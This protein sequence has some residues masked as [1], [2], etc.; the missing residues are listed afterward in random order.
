MNKKLAFFII[1]GILGLVAISY[2]PFPRAYAVI[3]FIFAVILAYGIS[4]LHDAHEEFIAEELKV[5]RELKR[6]YAEDRNKMNE[7]IE[8]WKGAEK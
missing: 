2:T 1:F 4:F 3:N 5:I 7:I 6:K 8:M